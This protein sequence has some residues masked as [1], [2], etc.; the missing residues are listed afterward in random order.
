MSLFPLLNNT[1]FFQV[2]LALLLAK[3]YRLN[4]IIIVSIQCHV[5]YLC[6]IS[7]LEE[8]H[9]AHNIQIEYE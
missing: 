7:I 1:F 3:Y 2:R 8:F 9:V 6:V 4:T 5:L